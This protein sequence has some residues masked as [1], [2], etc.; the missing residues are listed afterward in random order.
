MHCDDAARALYAAES[1]PGLEIHLSACDECRLLA[2]D[3]AGLNRAFAQARA[4]WAPS[5]GFKI[6]LPPAV[7]WRRLA[8]AASLLLVPLAGAAWMSLRAEAPAAQG[9][10]SALLQPEPAATPLPTDRQILA[11]L[12]LPEEQP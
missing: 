6:A 9:D 11:T 12:L 2:Q 5:S 4:E 10:L 3:L 1:S 7:N 8:V